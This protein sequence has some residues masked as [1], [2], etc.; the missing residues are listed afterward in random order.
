MSKTSVSLTELKK[1]HTRFEF[2]SL[3]NFAIIA[4]T[5]NLKDSRTKSPLRGSGCLEAGEKS[6][7]IH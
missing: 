1:R 4:Y 3:L 6:L 5:R 7:V 2:L